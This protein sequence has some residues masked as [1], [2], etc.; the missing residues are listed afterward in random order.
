ML[1][2]CEQY[3][4][5]GGDRITVS[6]LEDLQNLLGIDRFGNCVDPIEHECIIREGFKML[7]DLG[8]VEL[9]GEFRQS[10]HGILRI[11]RL[12]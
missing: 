2:G 6:T 7:M 10:G 1:F 3:F 4:E 11:V 9:E 8:A 12:D 5:D